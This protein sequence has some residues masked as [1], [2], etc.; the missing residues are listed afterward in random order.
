VCLKRRDAPPLPLAPGLK[1][2]GVAPEP[3]RE[4][5][6]TLATP[7][8]ARVP[9][10]DA[11]AGILHSEG[12]ACCRREQQPGM[13]HQAVALAVAVGSVHAVSVYA[14][15]GCAHGG[16][17]GRPAVGC[18][19]HV[20]AGVCQRRLRCCH[21]LPAAGQVQRQASCRC[22]PAAGRLAGWQPGECA[23]W[24]STM[25]TTG[26]GSRGGGGGGGRRVRAGRHPQNCNPH[27]PPQAQGCW[28]ATPSAL[29][30]ECAGGRCGAGCGVVPLCLTRQLWVRV[31]WVAP[32]LPRA[33]PLLTMHRSWQ[34]PLSSFL[35][36]SCTM[37]CAVGA[38][39][40]AALQPAAPRCGSNLRRRRCRHAHAGACRGARAD[41]RLPAR[42]RHHGLSQLPPGAAPL[43]HG[44]DL[45]PCPMGRGSGRRFAP[46]K[47]GA[48]RRGA[49]R[50]PVPGRPPPPP[51]RRA[52]PH[53]TSI[54]SRLHRPRPL[55]PQRLPPVL[56]RAKPATPWQLPRPKTGLQ[57]LVQAQNL[58]CWPAR[59][60]QRVLGTWQRLTP[61]IAAAGSLEPEAGLTYLAQRR[62][63]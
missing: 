62:P 45:L 11:H 38:R 9:W 63:R 61:A 24:S 25:H 26:K 28:R 47:R 52:S 40:A 57:S 20:L 27:H 42:S 31:L 13:S 3:A 60:G 37:A 55:G 8:A 18:R 29:Q 39:R 50:A 17:C 1:G 58:H 23:G 35:H 5:F 6:C 10:F 48:A 30:R 14:S 43:G 36:A 32:P 46:A 22:P 53:R 49:A 33:S 51:R 59:T 21:R 44:P 56:S 4:C 16:G 12:R 34:G 19:W 41:A 7:P 15:G 2:G 54:T